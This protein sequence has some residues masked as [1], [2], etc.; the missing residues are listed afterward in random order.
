MMRIAIVGGGPGGLLT[1]YELENNCAGM[2]EATLFEASPRIGGKIVTRQFQSAP[3]L[4]EAGVAELYGYAHLGPDSVY[5]LVKTLGLETVEMVGTAVILGDTIL[6]E[7]TDIRQFGQGSLDALEDFYELCEE[8]LDS[9]DYYQC[10]WLDDNKHPWSRKT[11]RELL[12]TIPD[13]I[14]RKYIEVGV[15]SDVATEPHL[16]NALNGLK[17]ILMDDAEYLRTYSIK[18]GNER[19]IEALE[20]RLKTTKFVLGAA[21]T[22]VGK[23]AK[24][25]YRI[26]TRDKG[27]NK[28]HEFDIVVMAVP[29]YWLARI[30]WDSRDLRMAMQ[31]HLAAYD[32][33]AHY[34]RISIFFEKPFWRDKVKGSFFMSDTFGGCCIYDEGSWHESGS[35]GV[36]AWLLTS[37]DAMAL[38]NFDDETL[39]DMVLDSLPAP[40]AEGRSLF[41]EGRVQRWVGTISGQPGGSPV[42]SLRERHIPAAETHPNLFVVGDYLFDSTVNGTYDSAD[43]VVDTIQ[44]I[45]RKQKYAYQLETEITTQ[46]VNGKGQPVPLHMDYYELYDGKRPYEESFE[47]YFC[48]HYTTDLIREVWGWSPPYKL[49]NGGSAN[50][51]TLQC[52]EAKGVKAWGIE[53]NPLIHARTAEKWKSRNILGSV[54]NLPFEDKSFDFIYD[55]CRS[56]KFHRRG[57]AP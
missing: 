45:L 26:T 40:L 43:F 25:K 2:F 44:T 24:G 12:D 31:K 30:E 22:Y 34:L 28:D 21:V 15:R 29:N 42:K 33:P 1:A 13:E 18:G 19:L 9:N 27:S 36:L 5:D 14:A 3:V 32:N 11:F 37:N 38:A 54:C 8:M 20:R 53:F 47:E 6:N 7:Y 52:F 46:A 16:T 51:L 55:T 4:Y 49:L 48:E 56:R 50:G 57:F 39:L 41:K 35:Y 23:T 10:H 17:N